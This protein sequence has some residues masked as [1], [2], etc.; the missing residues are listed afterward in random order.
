MAYRLDPEDREKMALFDYA[1]DF[2]GKRVLEI[3]CGNGRLT[4][5][6]AHLTDHVTGIDPNEEKIAQAITETPPGLHGKVAFWAGGMDT[7]ETMER[8]DL[9]LFSWSL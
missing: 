2:A 9:A 5:Q 3:G 7:F 1:G 4:W 6:Y 8:F